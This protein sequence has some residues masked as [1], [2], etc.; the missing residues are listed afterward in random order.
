MKLVLQP[1]HIK[2]PLIKAD[3][4]PHKYIKRE[5]IYRHG[6]PSWRYY[7]RDDEQRE[8]SKKELDPANE[9]EHATIH[10]IGAYHKHLKGKRPPTASITGQ[11]LGQLLGKSTTVRMSSTFQKSH[12]QDFIKAESEGLAVE[13]NPVQRVAQALELLPDAVKKLINIKTIRIVSRSEPK[14]RELFEKGDPP[15]PVPATWS[16]SHGNILLCADGTGHGGQAGFNTEPSGAAGFGRGLTL[17][18]ELVWHEIGKNLRM[19]LQSKRKVVAAEWR[20]LSEDPSTTKISA[21][22]NQ[23]WQADF[24]ESFAAMMS[25]PKQMAQQCPERYEFFQ[26]NGLAAVPPLEEMASRAAGEFAW[27]E[28]VEANETRIRYLRKVTDAAVAPTTYVSEQDEFYTMTRNG[29]TIY[30]RVGPANVYEE[31]SWEATPEIIDPISGLPT[32][33]TKLAAKFRS[34]A[35][36]KEIFDEHGNLLD[37]EAAFLYLWQDDDVDGLPKAQSLSDQI[38]DA[39]GQKRAGLSNTVGM[40]EAQIDK[41]APEKERKAVEKYI[42]QGMLLEKRGDRYARIPVKIPA[43]EFHAKTPSFAFSGMRE[44]ANQPFEV[45]KN[46][47]AVLDPITKKPLL[48]ARVYEAL[49]PDGTKSQITI[50]ESSEFNEG[51]E[52][53]LPITRKVEDPDSEQVIQKTSWETVTL[54]HRIHGED[55]SAKALARKFGANVDDILRRNN[56]FGQYQIQD[57]LMAALVNPE[58]AP[59]TSRD[60]LIAK[61]RYAAEARVEKWVSIQVGSDTP[62]TTMQALVRFDGAGS[63]LLVGSYWQRKLGLQNPRVSDL[64]EGGQ[65]KGVDKAVELKPRKKRI[66]VGHTIYAR[67]QGQMVL[68]QLVERISD[69]GKVRGYQVNV[70]PGQAVIDGPATAKQIRAIPEN[71]D[72]DRPNIRL[73]RMRAPQRDLLLY[74]DEVQLDANGAVIPGSGVVKIKLPENG[75]WGFEEISRVPGVRIKD[76]ELLFDTSQLEAFRNQVGGFI[77]DEHVRVKLN[78]KMQDAR[79]RAEAGRVKKVPLSEIVNDDG[80][81]RLDGL[82]KGMRPVVGGRKFQLGSHQAR[83]LQNLIENNGRILAAH[84]MG[85]GKTVS[86]ITAI[87]MMQN[88]NGTAKR[89]LVIAP[90]NVVPQWEQEV[91][92]FTFGKATVVGS[93]SLPGALQVWS[94]PDNLKQKPSGW[95]DEKYNAELDR[96]RAKAKGTYWDPKKD[97]TDIVVVSASYFQK[98]AAELRRTGGFD[99]M[100]LDESQGYQYLNTKRAKAMRTFNPD[101]NFMMHLSGTPWTNTLST[102]TNYLRVLSNGAVDYGDPEDFER[103]HMV[104]SSVLKAAGSTTPTKMDINPNVTKELLP[105]MQRYVHV[106][107]PSDV[108]GKVMPAALIDE[109]TPTRMTPIHSMIYRGYMRQLTPEDATMLASAAAI[110]EDEQ[111]VVSEEGKRSILAAR[112]VANCPAFKPFDGKEFVT[113]R[114]GEGKRRKDVILKLPTWRELTQ[115]F[116]G[117]FPSENDVASGK[118]EQ[119]EFAMLAKWISH[120]VGIDYDRLT[121]QRVLDM[122]SPEQARAWRA[123]ED[124]GNGIAAGTKIPNPEFGPEGVICR[125][126]VV[127]GKIVPLEHA[128]RNP[129]G[130]VR[131]TIRVPVGYRF[132]RNPIAKGEAKFFAAGLPSSH[133]DADKVPN[134]WDYSKKVIDTDSASTSGE[135]ESTPADVEKGQ[136][137]LPGREKLDVNTSPQRRRERL[138]LDLVMTEGNSKCDD[139]EKWINGNLDGSRGGDPDAQ[140]VIFGGA[141]S[142]ACR[143]VEAKLR[144]MGYQDVNEA[145]N[146]ALKAP[147]DTPPAMGKYFVTYMGSGSLGNRDI[148]SEIFKRSKGDQRLSTFVAKTMYGKDGGLNEGEMAEPWN[149]KQRDKIDKLFT[150]VT[151]PARVALVKEGGQLVHKYAYDADVKPSD[152]KKLRD[153]EDRFRTAKDKV[154]VQRQIDNIYRK[155]LV[156]RVPLDKRQIHVFNNCQFMVASDAAQVGMNWGNATHLALYDSLFS[157]MEEWQRITRVARM[158]GEALPAKAHK[159]LDKLAKYIDQGGQQTNFSEYEGTADRAIRIVE[160][161]MDAHPDVA[162]ELKAA[163]VK[164]NLHQFAESYLATR[165]LDKMKDLRAQVGQKLRA[166][167]RVLVG[168]PKVQTGF[169][170]DGSPKYDYQRVKSVEIT[171]AD[172]TNE[173]VENYLRPFEREIL[174][175]RKYL[176]DVRRFVCSAEVPEMR[177]ETRKR[178]NTKGRQRKTY[179]VQVP[180]GRTIV[181]PVC[182]AEQAVLTRGRAKQVPMERLLSEVQNEMPIQTAFDFIPA[183]VSSLAKFGTHVKPPKTAAEVKAAQDRRR[184]YQKLRAMERERSRRIAAERRA[185]KKKVSA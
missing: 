172:I 102:T 110:G 37:D 97:D 141:I 125:G 135:D 59:I 56:K 173:I 80:T 113:F 20:A 55:L 87:K 185:S 12:V 44:A 166:E 93:K 107:L 98:H 136:R 91:Q 31:D 168:S 106:A 175:S 73:R 62:P 156:P 49:N 171:D 19:Q 144:M 81:P 43:A 77:M 170:D 34:P 63:P 160:D 45:L 108:S 164:M 14:V 180:T 16:D 174:R 69:G 65:L 5:R 153:L 129:D 100:V 33:T 162:A 41:I 105:I 40:T 96:L 109:N 150:G 21:V 79:M 161:V 116:K 131:T 61:L 127:N 94:P 155:Y 122:L 48:H 126:R 66:E 92:N 32:M 88:Y 167:G 111:K 132:A 184:E 10:E 75:Q 154:E 103:T 54:S 39:F 57:P 64:I 181:E 22:A 86:A 23:N 157:P 121:G 133:P 72:L 42:K 3:S 18:E 112:N 68:A 60:D 26:R 46:G 177:T 7:Y 50:T 30:F 149:P 83:L 159:A 90:S 76:Q 47:K 114:S 137:P 36:Y 143:T 146:D 38:F 182:H 142:S 148:N 51:D 139:M 85:T 165:A 163:D 35:V 13:R 104:P 115:Q 124:I 78:H 52:V 89:V 6:K 179:K 183:Q 152:R 84:F 99:G 176:K 74:A 178:E 145:L 82:L 123:G 27:W 4:R 15:R 95:S 71:V 130:S 29:R 8:R 118:L 24:A 28:G 151:A 138:M 128:I 11:Y 1:L 169:N 120:A 147:E 134:D 70:L 25:H 58:G 117:R 140:H 2:D 158:M 53:L 9:D 67:V 101:L 17:T 119:D